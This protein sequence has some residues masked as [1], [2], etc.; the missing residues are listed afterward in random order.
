MIVV[1]T[2]SAGMLGRTVVAALAAKGHDVRASTRADLDVRSLAACRAALTPEVDV[3]VNSSAWTGVDGAETQEAAA[4]A[5]NATGAAN[6]ALAAREARARMVHVST[7][8]VFDGR[9][10]EPYAEEAPLNPLGA[11]G[12]TKAAGEWAVTSFVPDAVIVRTAW[13]YG[14]GAPSFVR[15]MAR[16]AG[17]RETVTVVDDQRG[18]PTTTRDVARYVADVVDRADVT[19]VLHATSEGEATWF[20]LARA[21]FEELGLDAERV[22]P[23]DSTA[24]PTPAPRP[25]YSVLGHERT[26]A[27]GIEP[28]PPWRQALAETLAATLADGQS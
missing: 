8:Y 5:V 2:G 14:P 11:Y 6:L 15:T 16:L 18:Q 9:A 21:V 13:L 20:S 10:N 1:V 26:V 22:R 19:G 23:V 25:A 3:V 28:L 24:Y 27:L 17:E 4:F 7:D 12:R